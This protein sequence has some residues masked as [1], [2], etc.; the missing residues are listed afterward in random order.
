MRGGG[1]SFPGQLQRM[2]AQWATQEPT[3]Y[4]LVSALMSH[5]ASLQVLV[6]I[7]S[8]SSIFVS[9]ALQRISLPLL[10]Q[11]QR[12][13]LLR[14]L[15]NFTVLRELQWIT[16]AYAFI[17]KLDICDQVDCPSTRRPGFRPP[18]QHTSI[19]L[20]CPWASLWIS[21]NPGPAVLLLTL[22]LDHPAGGVEQA[23]KNELPLIQRSRASQDNVISLKRCANNED[24]LFALRSFL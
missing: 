10:A 11:L 3:G 14:F 19:L 6:I 24:I 1:R 12:T 2:I 22:Y 18:W 20:K 8:I 4:I 9:V 16:T 23:E 15:L 7:H 17:S 5:F 13:A 21:T